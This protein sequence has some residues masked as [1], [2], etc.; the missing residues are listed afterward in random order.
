MNLVPRHL[1]PAAAP[2]VVIGLGVAITSGA[3][4]SVLAGSL[5][6][7]LILIGINLQMSITALLLIQHRATQRVSRRIDRSEEKLVRRISSTGRRAR[8]ESRASHER[9]E[10]LLSEREPASAEDADGPGA[11]VGHSH[12]EVPQEVKQILFDLFAAASPPPKEHLQK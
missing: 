11:G 12:Q 2:L 6:W 3:I 10:R 4:I 7:G 9:V 1:R 5:A 8:S